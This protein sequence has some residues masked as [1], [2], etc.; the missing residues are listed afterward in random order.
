MKAVELYARVRHA[1]HVEGLS[2]REAARRFG[3]DPKTVAKMLRHAVPP[4]YRRTKPPARPKL[5][6]FTAIIDQILASDRSAPP[7]Q[8]HTAR[9]IHDRLRE[10]HGFAGSYTIVKDYVRE[11]QARTREV[12]VPLAHPPG[13]AQVD[14]GE[15]VAVIG[16]ERRKV[17][18]FCLDL[19]H[20]D[21]CF[22]KAYPAERTEAFLDGH[23]AAFAFLGGVPRSILYD[24]TRL[25][26][27]RILGAGARCVEM[28]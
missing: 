4:G 5:G 13:H 15:A 26:V 27:A 18:L 17:H 7:K 11:R 23:N 19:P 28:A 21:A 20:S 25:A 2:Q 9:R 8:R 16:G 6:A 24:N 1:C 22:V 10:E 12:F 14:F 3:I